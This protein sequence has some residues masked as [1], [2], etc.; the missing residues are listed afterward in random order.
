MQNIS[1]IFEN[2]LFP[3]QNNMEYRELTFE[4]FE[5]AL[6]SIKRNQAAGHD[7]ID[8]NVII[9]LYDEMMILTLFEKIQFTLAF[10]IDLSKAFDTVD[11]S[12]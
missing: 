2:F 9:K 8:S 7:D 3:I 12:T 10:F 6:K 4:E 5:K 11:H 1:N